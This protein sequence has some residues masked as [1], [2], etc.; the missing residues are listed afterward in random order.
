MLGRNAAAHPGL[1]KHVLA[2][3]HT[4]AH[5]SYRHPLLNRMSLVHAEAEID[6]GI[7]A[8]EAAVYG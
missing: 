7:A 2:E 5:H 3:G 6:L 1:A 8:V 4:V